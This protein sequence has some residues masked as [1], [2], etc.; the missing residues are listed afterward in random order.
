MTEQYTNIA[1]L[2]AIDHEILWTE[3]AALR[4]AI[5]KNHAPTAVSPSGG[6]VQCFLSGNGISLVSSWISAS[7]LPYRFAWSQTDGRHS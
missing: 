6:I 7:Y 2:L 3:P 5:V 1:A 4:P